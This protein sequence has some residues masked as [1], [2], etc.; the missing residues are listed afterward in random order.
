MKLRILARPLVISLLSHENLTL[1][2]WCNRNI[3]ICHAFHFRNIYFFLRLL[4]KFDKV[5][6]IR[7]N[8]DQHSS[9][10]IIFKIFK[11]TSNKSIAF[12]YLKKIRNISFGIFVVV[13]FASNYKISKR[14][15]MTSA[16]TVMKNIY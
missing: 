11:L 8:L 14:M 3:L 1:L 6:K 12:V 16:L 4:T 9:N 13:K 2:I 15:K 7:N 10:Y 5:L